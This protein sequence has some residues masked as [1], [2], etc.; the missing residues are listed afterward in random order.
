MKKIFSIMMAIA[1]TIGSVEAYS[2][3]SVAA[4]KS[5]VVSEEAI[6]Y[7]KDVFENLKEES[8]GIILGNSED[9]IIKKEYRLGSP[10]VIYDSDCETQDEIYYFPIQ[11]SNDRIIYILSIMGTNY[12]WNYCLSTE[13]IGEIKDSYTCGMTD[14]FYHVKNKLISETVASDK[15]KNKIYMGSGR[16]RDIRKELEKRFVKT[17]IDALNMM[18]DVE[19]MYNPSFQV[20]SLNYKKCQLHNKKSNN[21]HGMCWASSVSTICN[22]IRG[23][24]IDPIN[25]CGLMGIGPD[26]G[27]IDDVAQDALEKCG[28]RYPCNVSVQMTYKR[29]KENIQLK[30]PIYVH[31]KRQKGSGHAVTVYGYLYDG[32]VE[33]F[34]VWDPMGKGKE[35]KAKYDKNGSSITDDNKTYVWKSSLSMV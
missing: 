23:T 6:C 32:K 3:V 35:Y 28:V 22:Y 24:N 9:F 8:E 11:D 18:K 34:F 4:I 20:D 13:W 5:S 2:G 25:V 31:G 30:Y 1:L 17:D 12:G 27:A 16:A 26:A 14:E 19:A 33:H 7:A 15:I 10:F 21:G 29:I